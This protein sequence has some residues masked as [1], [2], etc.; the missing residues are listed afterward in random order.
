[1][2]EQIYKPCWKQ[3]YYLSQKKLI[4]FG[5]QVD[6]QISRKID[7]M[8]FNTVLGIFLLN[9]EFGTQGMSTKDELP[10]MYVLLCTIS[11][12]IWFQESTTHGEVLLFFM[13]QTGT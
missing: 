12:D 3:G 8:A 10:S 4:G 9:S 6:G 11:C 7:D 1:M 13:W 2:R 5:F